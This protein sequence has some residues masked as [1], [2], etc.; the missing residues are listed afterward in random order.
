MKERFITYLGLASLSSI[1]WSSIVTYAL[2][3]EKG[4]NSPIFALYNIIREY[5]LE[6]FVC[7]MLISACCMIFVTREN[8]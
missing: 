7:W 1:I 5:P 4:F 2:G 3:R 6:C 8:A